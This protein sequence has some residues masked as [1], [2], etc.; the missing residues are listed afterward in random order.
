MR[1]LLFLWW[2]AESHSF[3]EGASRCHRMNEMK[4]SDAATIRTHFQEAHFWIVRRGSIERVGEPTR[5]FNP[6]H[7]GIQVTRLDILLPDY[8][9]YAMMHVHQS[10]YWVGMAH[11]TLS[12]VNIRVFDVQ[13]IEL[14]PR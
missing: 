4:L 6:E 5:V 13:R 9:Y 2:H 1:L 11:G 12:L 3:S 7:I 8:L 10:G 14:S